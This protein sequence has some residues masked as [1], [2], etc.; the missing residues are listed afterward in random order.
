MM[1]LIISGRLTFEILKKKVLTKRFRIKI[2]DFQVA[3]IAL[4]LV[5]GGFVVMFF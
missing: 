3:K 1:F 5:L 4:H 2:V